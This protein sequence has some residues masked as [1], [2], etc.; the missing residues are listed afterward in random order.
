MT[1]GNRGYTVAEIMLVLGLVAALLT[2]LLPLGR[3]QLG[4]AHLAQARLALRQNARAIE[5]WHLTGQRRQ[6][7]ALPITDT[8]YY[9]ISFTAARPGRYGHYRLAAHPR[10][11]WLG[12]SYLLMDQDGLIVECRPAPVRCTGQNNS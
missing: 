7:P 8:G 5:R 11:H 12:P 4:R 1:I 2:S 6:W 9:R 10:H 3:A